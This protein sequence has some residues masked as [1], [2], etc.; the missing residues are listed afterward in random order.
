MHCAP[1]KE[2]ALDNETDFPSHIESYCSTSCQAPSLAC[3]CVK[4]GSHHCFLCNKRLGCF[5]SERTFKLIFTFIVFLSTAAI[6]GEEF[7]IHFYLNLLGLVYY[8]SPQSQWF[9]LFTPH[10][11]P[12]LVP[13]LQF[14]DPSI[15]WAFEGMPEGAKLPLSSWLV[16]L[17]IL[18]ALPSLRL[19]FHCLSLRFVSEAMG[20]AR[21]T[22]LPTH[23]S[24]DGTFK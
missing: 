8:D 23:S 10:I 11:P 3:Y 21:E 2:R 18:D 13:S 19:R 17:L 9:G 15:L 6:S 14:R 7:G 5:V 16:P 22:A 12:Y 1:A 20:R 4:F 24:S